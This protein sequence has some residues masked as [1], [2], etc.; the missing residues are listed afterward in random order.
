MQDDD[1]IIVKFPYATKTCDADFDYYVPVKLVPSFKKFISQ[2]D[3]KK[4]LECHVDANFA[5]NW[6][7]ED[8]TDTEM[9]RS[10]HGY[11]ISYAGCPLICKYQM[12][13]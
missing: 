13:V 6:D 9:A 11:I 4:G 8:M 10:W 3:T 12:Q 7:P 1:K 2:L 5:G